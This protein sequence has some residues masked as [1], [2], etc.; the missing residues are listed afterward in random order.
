MILSTIFKFWKWDICLKLFGK[1]GTCPTTVYP[2]PPPTPLAIDIL[3]IN[4]GID[5]DLSPRLR[6]LRTDW[7]KKAREIKKIKIRID[8]EVKKDPDLAKELACSIKILNNSVMIEKESI[9]LFRL[10]V[11]RIK[12]V[13]YY[14]VENDTDDGVFEIA[15]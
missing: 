9:E 11:S 10:Q 7:L 4:D 8:E 13:E 6:K 14:Y 3:S 5:S 12:I 2:C 1:K 15:G